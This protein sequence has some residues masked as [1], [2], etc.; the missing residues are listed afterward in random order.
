M[1]RCNM[2]ELSINAP[3]VASTL[4]QFI[5]DAVQEFRRDG[6]IVGL[7]GGI[8]S[9]VVATLAVRALGVDKV[10]GLI[11]PE[12]DSHPDSARLARHLADTLG[13]A[14]ETFNLTPLLEGIG[15][16][17][18]LP[19]RWIPFRRLR[20]TMVRYYYSRFGS[21]PGEGETLFSA[22][23]VGT[24]GLESP[25]LNEG[26]AYHR[27]KVRLRMVLLYYYAERRNLLVLGTDNRTELA[28]GFF[29]KYG[30][31]AA[32]VA[33]LAPLYKTQVRA[34]A[35]Y[36]NVPQEIIARPPSPDV[37][38]GLSD[39]SAI[40]MDYTTLDRILWRLERGMD[41]QTTAHEVGVT[42][43]QVQYVQTL[44]QRAG[45]LHSPA[46]VPAL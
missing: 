18:L 16:Y 46:K 41:I 24:Q 43:E 31:V 20:E 38:P 9:A 27:C 28:I 17:R 29:V 40:G 21:P 35:E 33:P 22:V 2:S 4:Q 19:L 11:L 45:F 5:R 30:D 13:I 15:V 36:L 42:P 6:A 7:S 39:E 25:W 44:R 14:C 26:V 3:Q 8:D 37:L 10:L 34:L 1:H 12:R 23:M 32:D